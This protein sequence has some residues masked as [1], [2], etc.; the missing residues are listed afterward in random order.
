MFSPL[1]FPNGT[2]VYDMRTSDTLPS[3][4]FLVPFELYR[5]TLV[6]LAI[7]DGKE[8]NIREEVAP[9]SHGDD[10]ADLS[11]L[12]DCIPILKEKALDSLCPPT[13]G[14]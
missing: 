13:S 11:E 7:S 10:I 8:Y 9:Y 1:G 12:S 2:V 4:R 3:H 5:E 14:I 6:V